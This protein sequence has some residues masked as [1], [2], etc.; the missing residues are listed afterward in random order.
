MTLKTTPKTVRRFAK[1]FLLAALSLFSLVMLQFGEKM[2]NALDL[3]GRP[4]VALQVPASRLPAAPVQATQTQNPALDFNVRPS[5]EAAKPRSSSA[6]QP[7]QIAMNTARE[8]QQVAQDPQQLATGNW[9]GASFPVEGFQAYTSPF[10]YRQS[11]TGGYS[12]EFHYGLDMAAPEGS[13]VRNWWT[14]KVVELTD[15]TNCGTSVVVE[16][17]PWTHIYCH[18]MGYVEEDSSGRYMVDTEGGVKVALGDTVSAGQRIGRV[19]M[20]GRTTGPH[21]HWGLKYDSGWVDPAFVIRAMYANQRSASA[22][23][24]Q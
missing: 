7:Q 23:L 5:A 17:G 19:G 3:T 21:L 8:A 1:F 24:N 6:S 14:G 15:D 9:S 16:S 18:M 4:E 12:Q 2:V 20:T 10:G 22:N 11:A 13:Y